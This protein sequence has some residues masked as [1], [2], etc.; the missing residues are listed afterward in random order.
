MKN[1]T[2][3][4]V[5]ILDMS[6][7]MYEM[8]SDTI[9]GFNSVLAEHRENGKTVLIST[10][11]FNTDYRLLHDRLPVN[12][13][14]NITENEYRA[15]GGTALI[16]AIG[17]SIKHIEDVHKYIRPEDVPG[18]TIFMIT[19]DGLE[20]ASHIY[21]SDTV[22]Q[23]ITAK[24]ENGWDF[25]FLAA[26]I[27]AV[28]TAKEYGIKA[29]N[30]VN[31]HNDSIGNAL[32]FQAMTCFMKMAKSKPKGQSLDNSTEWREAADEDYNSRK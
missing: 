11:L 21:S 23:M 29:N 12:E 1:N 17:S 31:Y 19:T 5:F 20:N 3:E 8:T 14:P 32:K 6:G 26:N 9:G 10:V 7:S 28:E 30:A 18:R 16:D 15:S 25:V 22:K 4:V 13:V 2:V 27:D 24:Q